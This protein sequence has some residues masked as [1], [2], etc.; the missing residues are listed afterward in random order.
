MLLPSI[1]SA[2]TETIRAIRGVAAPSSSLKV[3]PRKQSQ[4]AGLGSGPSSKGTLQSYAFSAPPVGVRRK[5][6]SDDKAELTL[7]DEWAVCAA[8]AAWGTMTGAAIGSNWVS[9]VSGT[10]HPV[11]FSEG[12]LWQNFTV[13]GIKL[14]YV[15]SNSDAQVGMG[16]MG[17]VDTPQSTP[18]ADAISSEARATSLAP[19]TVAFPFNQPKSFTVPHQRSWGVE[20]NIASSAVSDIQDITPGTIFA[21]GSGGSPTNVGRI[22]VEIT[23]I[24]LD[25]RPS[26]AGAGLVALAYDSCSRAV[27]VPA[28]AEARLRLLNAIKYVHDSC[29]DILDRPPPAAPAGISDRELAQGLADILKAQSTDGGRG[30]PRA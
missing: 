27:S 30:K 14:H 25:K 17:Y 24:V 10:I 23:Y 19:N 13:K 9:P 16:V 3:A 28:R 4:K 2:V 22:F 26:Y 1:T 21:Y 8:P 11:S 7:C 15:P 6:L 20:R 12:L 29:L 18:A 5:Q